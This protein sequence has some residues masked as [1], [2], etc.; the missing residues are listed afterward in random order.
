MSTPNSSS[1]RIIYAHVLE[2]HA[3]YEAFVSL[4]SP[5]DAEE[6]LQHELEQEFF[7]TLS[8]LTL[9]LRAKDPQLYQHC[10]R[11]QRITHFLTQALK[12]PKEEGITIELAG[13][14]HDI[15]KIAIHNDVLQK[16]TCLTSEEYQDVKGHAAR[17]AEILGHIK[18]LNKVV[19]MVHHHHER[20]DGHGY[21]SGL[22]RE[23]IPLGARILAI[24]DAFEV[25]TSHRAYSKT[26]TPAQ[27]LEELRRN[28]GTQFD[29]VL[30]D[31]FCSSMEDA[32]PN[33][34][35][36]E[37]SGVLFMLD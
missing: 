3:L 10:N 7:E 35:H 5:A 15:G 17:G 6:T 23:A 24:A 37:R 19:P 20:W 26:R 16:P 27:A 13:L 21:P 18:M 31:R 28:A 4:N 29:P 1:Q 30:V 22:C 12:L 9:T 33:K 2:Q 11:V 8:I 14:F 36:L 25:M 32:F 34:N